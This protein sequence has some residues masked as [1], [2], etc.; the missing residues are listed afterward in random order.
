[1][2]EITLLHK[3]TDLLCKIMNPFNQTDKERYNIVTGKAASVDAK[4]FL[5]SVNV[6]GENAKK[7]FM[8]EC[9][10][11]PERFRK[12]LQNRK[13]KYLKMNWKKNSEIQWRRYCSLLCA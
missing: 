11:R 8:G 2:K 5:L 10:K 12:N 9:I 3:V 13:C 6:R 7:S 1:M 4:E